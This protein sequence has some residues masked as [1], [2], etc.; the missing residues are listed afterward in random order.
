M[1]RPIALC[2][3]ALAACAAPADDTTTTTSDYALSGPVLDL[4]REHVAGDVYHYEAVLAVGDTPNAEL[5][6]HRVVRE[7]APWIPRAGRAAAMMLHGDFSTF[8]TNYLPDG[9]GMAGYLAAR[10]IDVWGVDRRWASAP[11]DADTSD[12]GDMGL[13]QELGDV[14]TALGFARAVRLLHG[15]TDRLTLVG[16]SRG[17]QL[18][19]AY[20]SQ[21]ATRAV[22]HVDGLVPLDVYFTLA[23]EDEATRQFFCDSAAFERQMLA[24]GVVDSE[25]SFI[26]AAGSLAESAP[27][28]ESPLFPGLTNRQAML[29]L[30]GQTYQFAPFTPLYHLIAPVLEGDLPV[31][32]RFSDEG[33]VASWL[34]GASPHQS[35]REAAESDALWCGDA[36]LP[37]DAPLDR[38]EIPLYYLGAA[39]GMGDHG[40]YTTTLVSSADVTTDV[41]A[42]GV[43]EAEDF[44]H[45]DLL[46]ATDAEA[47]AWKP[48]A[49]WIEA[50]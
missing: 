44:G 40:L 49:A 27:D 1:F 9:G 17:G 15:R 12:F 45:A 7:R 18:A 37:I 42:R 43:G 11:A 22:R 41:I 47:L 38:I 34:A 35:M 2:T 25:N 21:E 13:A 5:H 24:D 46:F 33:V 4:T 48:L 6:V 3:L 8:R 20:A 28:D 31:G 29:V 30:V 10:G 50:H 16:F 36:P 32:L 26:I 23:P 39:G 14:R 19:Y